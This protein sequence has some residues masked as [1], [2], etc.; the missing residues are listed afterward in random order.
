M[1]IIRRGEVVLEKICSSCTY[2]DHVVRRLVRQSIA[3]SLSLQ[4]RV[5]HV[6][7]EL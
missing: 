2:I 5:K 1:D 6:N 7:A 4:S 3:A